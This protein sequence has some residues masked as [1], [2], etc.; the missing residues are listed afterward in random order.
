MKA[1]VINLA[2]ATDRMAFQRRQMA[3]LGLEWERVEAITPDTLTPAA[4]DP[5]WDRWQR[6]L[7]STEMAL[8]ASHMA[9]WQKVS[10]AG[11]PMLIVEDDAMLSTALPPLLPRIE[12]T[13]GIEHLSLETRGRKKL[14]SRL[15]HPG[16]P[17]RRMFQ[18]RTGSAAYILFP[19]GADRLLAQTARVAAPSDAAIAGCPGLISWQADPALALQLDIADRYGVAPPLPT[20]SSIDAV[21][22]P[23][24]TLAHRRRRIAAQLRMGLTQL[25]YAAVARRKHV[26]PATGWLGQ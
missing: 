24:T 17:I 8:T 1:L 10:A 9:C 26:Q 5:M 23:P 3:D 4:D 12:T 7:R 15:T 21:A 20:T 18:D 6:P 22:K 25:T 11:V 16:L 2:R 13:A 19:N 14:L